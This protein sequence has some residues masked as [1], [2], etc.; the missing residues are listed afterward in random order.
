MTSTQP[1]VGRR[2][3]TD[4]MRDMGRLLPPL[5]R[6]NLNDRV[7]ARQQQPAP[8]G[9]HLA[10]DLAARPIQHKCAL[11]AMAL[12]QMLVLENAE[13]LANGGAGNPAFGGKIV[14]G[15]N[16]LARCPKPGLDAPPK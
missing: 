4:L 6:E 2:Q 1:A 7:L 5:V 15:R 13:R 3:L 11:G 8:I 9:R 10:P 14:D 16:L 12:D